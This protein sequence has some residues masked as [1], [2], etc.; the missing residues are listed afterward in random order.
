MAFASFAMAFV[1]LG[2]FLRLFFMRQR[3]DYFRGPHLYQRIQVLLDPFEGHALGDEELARLEAK[4]ADE[5]RNVLTG[6]GIVPEPWVLRVHADELLG[7][8]ARV[9]GPAGEVL[10]VAEFEQR[11]RDGRIDLS[12]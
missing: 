10:S 9:H 12:R 3:E 1:L 6:V 5:F 7:P 8:V 2:V 11:L 4:A